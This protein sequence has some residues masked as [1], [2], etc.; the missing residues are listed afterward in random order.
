M[1]YCTER[2]KSLDS[3]KV[4]KRLKVIRIFVLICQRLDTPGKETMS[5]RIC[6]IRYSS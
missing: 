3:L 5:Y 2:L 4:R 1:D 6:V